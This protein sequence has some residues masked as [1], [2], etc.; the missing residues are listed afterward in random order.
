LA[1]HTK[2]D[3]PSKLQMIRKI[4][5]EMGKMKEIDDYYWKNISK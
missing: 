5:E 3:V 1:S 4:N 2:D